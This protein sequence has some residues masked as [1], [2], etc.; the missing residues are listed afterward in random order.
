MSVSDPKNTERNDPEGAVACG[1][2]VVAGGQAAELLATGEQVLHLVAQAV[3]GTVEGTGA[4]LV[5]LARNTEPDPPATAVLADDPAT[6]AFVPSDAPRAQAG[7][8][9]TR[10]FDRPL[11]QQA[12]EDR[13]LVG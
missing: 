4:M 2:L 13:R 3:E 9:P 10:A 8:A 5:R 11:G 6:V 12:G 1:A 7:P